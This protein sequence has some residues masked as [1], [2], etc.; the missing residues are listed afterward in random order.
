MQEGLLQDGRRTMRRWAIAL[1]VYVITWC[2]LFAALWPFHAHLGFT[3]RV[4]LGVPFLCAY[5]V[6]LYVVKRL[7]L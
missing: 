2:V 4:V 6:A 3:P 5:V 7:D 1:A